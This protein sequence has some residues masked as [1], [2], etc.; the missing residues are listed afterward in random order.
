MRLCSSERPGK[1]TQIHLKGESWRGKPWGD[2]G[3]GRCLGEGFSQLQPYKQGQAASSAD[4]RQSSS[5]PLEPSDSLMSS[6]CQTW[7]YRIFGV[8][9]PGLQS[10]CWSITS[11][12]L[13]TQRMSVV[14]GSHK[15]SDGGH[16]SCLA[17]CNLWLS[18]RRAKSF[19]FFPHP[20]LL[21]C[22]Y[23]WPSLI[24]YF[25]ILKMDISTHS[26]L[27]VLRI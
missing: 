3:E 12:R 1:T 2:P 14:C 16:N 11:F 27:S 15:A 18:C 26:P 6:R 8:C 23:S 5:S 22:K 7:S 21:I 25:R 4:S 20:G 19:D 9:S 10:L 17:C 13:K 24:T